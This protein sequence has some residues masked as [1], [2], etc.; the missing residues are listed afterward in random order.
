MTADV[1]LLN[2]KVAASTALLPGV[3]CSARLH[4][5]HKCLLY[6]L[7]AKSALLC[8]LRLL[9]LLPQ[10]HKAAVGRVSEERGI[11]LRFPR[12]LRVR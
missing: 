6:T 7:T 5:R 11:G 3:L 8:L 10:V 2:R 1:C 9:C 12:F 4:H